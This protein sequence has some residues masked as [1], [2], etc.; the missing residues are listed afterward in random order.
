MRMEYQRS[1]GFGASKASIKA[2]LKYEDKVRWWLSEFALTHARALQLR[3]QTPRYGGYVDFTL[4][5]F[6]MHLFLIEVKSQ[7]SLD[8]YKQLLRYAGS[9]LSSVSRVCICK[10]FHPDI[11]LP[12]PTLCLRLANLLEAPPGKM[13][14]VPWSGRK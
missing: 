5:P 13:T 10:V 3:A 11:P 14:I 9:E 12:E 1:A 4:E 7:W 8:A 6:G 2:G